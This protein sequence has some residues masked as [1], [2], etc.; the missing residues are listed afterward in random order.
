M[1]QSG[2]EFHS[3]SE[4]YTKLYGNIEKGNKNYSALQKKKK[5]GN[6]K[7]QHFNDGEQRKTKNQI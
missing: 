4:I 3:K 2:N 5:K 7:P 1:L 6:K